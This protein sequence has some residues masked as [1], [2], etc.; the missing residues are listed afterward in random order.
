MFSVYMAKGYC[1]T[2]LGRDKDDKRLKESCRRQTSSVNDGL[3]EHGQFAQEPT[4]L[5]QEAHP[6]QM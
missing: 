4:G 3:A 1:S 6:A 2:A 5:K